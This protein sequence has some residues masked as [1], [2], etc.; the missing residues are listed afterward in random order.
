MHRINADGEEQREH[1]HGCDDQGGFMFSDPV[2]VL[3]SSRDTETGE[4]S[5]LSRHANRRGRQLEDSLA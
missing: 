5:G 4:D 1:D 2:H 3:L